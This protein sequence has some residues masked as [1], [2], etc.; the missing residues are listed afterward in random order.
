MP[1]YDVADIE[2][3]LA[4]AA[5]SWTDDLRPAL[6]E[7]F[8]EE[9]GLALFKRYRDAFPAAYSEDFFARTAGTDLDEELG[10]A[11]LTHKAQF[12]RTWPRPQG[13]GVESGLIGRR[14]ATRRASDRRPAPTR[15]PSPAGWRPRWPRPSHRTTGCARRC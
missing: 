12:S 5:R 2:S 13:S 9:R 4:E 1:A 15:R 3:R 6:C 10:L 7:R 8:G 14:S 11:K